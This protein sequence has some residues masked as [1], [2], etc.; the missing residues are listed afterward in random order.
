MLLTHSMDHSPSWETNQSLKPVK[1]F[2]AF[3]WNPKFLYRSQNCPPLLPILSQFHQVPKNPQSSGRFILIL[4]SPLRLGHP[5]GLFLSSF[6]TNIRCTPL[7]SPIRATC[8]AHLILLGFTN[9]KE[10]RSF[11]SSLCNF[12]HF[13]VTSSLL[14]PNY[15]QHPIL[16]HPQPTFLPQCQWTIFTPIQNNGQNYISACL[17]LSVFRYKTGR[18]MILHRVTSS[19]PWLQSALHLFLNRILICYLRSQ[20]FERFR[21]F[22]A[23]IINIHTVTSP[24]ILISTPNYELSFISIYS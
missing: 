11:S 22:N 15:S 5:S 14:G 6:P 21:H 23:T 4:S 8:S 20:I 12:H 16:K 1:K 24:C 2:P 17:D 10:Y 19:I 13:P 7:S 3:V 18:Q 9:H